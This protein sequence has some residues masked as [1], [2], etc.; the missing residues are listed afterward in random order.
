M[1]EYWRQ[2]ISNIKIYKG[3]VLHFRQDTHAHTITP[4]DP[5]MTLGRLQVTQDNWSG[6]DVKRYF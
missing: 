5:A 6:K 4:A 3:H 1:R 2:S